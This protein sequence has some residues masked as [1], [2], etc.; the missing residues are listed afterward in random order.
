[1]KNFSKSGVVVLTAVMALS[2]LS[3]CSQDESSAVKSYN[4]SIVAIQKDMFNTAQD[5]SKVFDEPNVG[6]DKVLSALKDIQSNIQSSHDKFTAMQVPSG[7]EQL[8]EAMGRFF[9]VEIKG[10]QNVIDGVQQLVGK[11]SDP[12]A[13]KAFSDTFAQFSSQESAALKDFYATQQQVADQYG[14]KVIQTDTGN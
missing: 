2:F 12:D 3:G 11:E 5:D 9:Q 4:N 7:A 13:R 1:M 14:Q 6:T 10:I 8:S